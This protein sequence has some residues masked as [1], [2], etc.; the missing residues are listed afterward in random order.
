M[1][2]VALLMLLFVSLVFHIFF[3]IL[4]LL[5][6]QKKHLHGFLNTAL[7]NI[8]IALA[9]I[10]A[11]VNKPALIRGINFAQVLWI[12]SGIIFFFA[13]GVKVNVLMRIY[14][15]FK[16]PA[17][18]HLNFFGKKVLNKDAVSKLDVLA[19]F[20][21]MPF[22]LVAGSYFIAR[23]INFILYGRL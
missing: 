1:I 4:Y 11:I 3:L 17:N 2:I 8:I 18:Y 22:F 12:F 19:F 13:L 9:I 10:I 16:N 14:R 5:K 6:V 7:I 21:A 23:L 20:G 15:T